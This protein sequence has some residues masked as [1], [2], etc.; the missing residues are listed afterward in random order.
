MD[1]AVDL[2]E[3]DGY[4]H[5]LVV[6]D[7]LT[8]EIELCKTRTLET[9]ELT[10]TFMDRIV[11]RH[12]FPRS[13]VSDRGAQFTSTFWRALCAK[14]GIELRM[15][16]AYQPETDGQ[17]E[18]AVQ[19][20]KD[21]LRK[22]IS[23]QPAKE[24]HSGSWAQWLPMCQLAANSRVSDTTG[25][26]PFFLTHGTTP[27]T[28]LDIE[29][30]S[31]TGPS[32]LKVA[33]ESLSQR[34]T[35]AWDWANAAIVVA[36]DDQEK[37]ANKGR[38]AAPA[39]KVGDKVW[40]TLRD[41]SRE[42]LGPRNAKYTILEQ[43]GSHN[44]RLDTPPGTLNTFHVNRLRPAS[45]DPH[46]SQRVYEPQPPPIIDNGNSDEAEYELDFISKER[47]KGNQPQVL[48]HWRGYDQATWEPRRE[49]LGTMEL[50][51][52]TADHPP[53]GKLRKWCNKQTT[54]ALPEIFSNKRTTEGRKDAV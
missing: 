1:Y 34:L 40:L 46:D 5:V 28:G 44:V 9:Q 15:S 27:R 53:R 10:S 37:H 29:P 4:K 36:Q 22:M 24:R 51:T 30:A 54:P 35:K 41:R 50:T 31:V 6:V 3:A 11:A 33:A 18:R 42:K 39:Y 48:V 13:I 38:R 49:L 21:L 20:T 32:S 16:T 7:R 45:N 8:K 17:S 14:A 19:T 26:A 12:G 52:W 25:F 47:W 23:A 43:V 2:P